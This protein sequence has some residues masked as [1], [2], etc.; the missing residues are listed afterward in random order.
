MTL[1]IFGF[2]ALWSPY[3]FLF[4]LLVATCYFLITVQ[5]RGK[6]SGSEPLT[7]R[8][9]IYFTAGIILV[10]II[11]GSP[12][13]L[14]GHLMFYVHMIQ[15]AFL[16]IV[17][18]PLFIFGIPP[19]LWRKIISAP[20]I[21]K[22]FRLLTKPVPAIL[23]FNGAFS[24]YHIPFIFDTVKT[25]LWLHAVHTLLLFLFAL[26]MWWPLV[27]EVDEEQK[28]GGLKRMFYLF[29]DGAL[30][31]P[32]CA[33]II[34]SNVPLYSSFSEPDIWLQALQLCVPDAMISSLNLSGPEMFHSLSL[35]HDQQLGGILM[36]LIQEAVYGSVLYRSFMKWY[37]EEQ[38]ETQNSLS[39]DVELTK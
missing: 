31:T 16:Y 24:F 30:L 11:K 19:W 35:L 10:Y 1:D 5:Y 27:N 22:P 14:L 39:M 4:L 20:W 34:F 18:P 29:A 17:I 26:F 36:K 28:L 9:A 8:Q 2:R 21:R 33:L 37:R 23:L 38:K 13:D 32:A 25:N 3:F 15:M 12:V 6:F 7:K